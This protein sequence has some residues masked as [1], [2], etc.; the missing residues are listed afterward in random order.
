MDD[1]ITR[2]STPFVP[3]SWGN[4]P[5]N[6]EG[7]RP[8]ARPDQSHQRSAVGAQRAVP[9]QET[10]SAAECCRGLGCPQILFCLSP[11]SGDKGG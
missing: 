4:D 6:A 7:L 10:D 2:L 8:S 9:L 3:Q 1:E 5:K 11:R